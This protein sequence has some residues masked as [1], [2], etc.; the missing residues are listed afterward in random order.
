MK[1]GSGEGVGGYGP[2]D[3]GLLISALSRQ[4]VGFEGQ[5][6]WSSVPDRAATMLFG[7][8]QNH[9]FH[10][11]NKRTA[12]LS[13]V[14]YLYRNGY[15]ITV[16]E[17]A[18]EDL[19]V[20]IAT[21]GLRKFPRFRE[22]AKKDTDPEVRFLSH[23]LRQNT[24]KIDRQQYFITY[25]EL[26]KIL[27]RYDA[28]LENP[29]DNSIDLMRWETVKKKNGFF[30]KVSTGSEARRV[31]ALGFP[32]WTK[33]VGKGRISHIRKVLDLTPEFGVD[34]QAF[35]KDVDDMRVLI[36]MYEG[37]LERLAYR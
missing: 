8:I 18:L 28:W 4:F 12:Y 31:C 27:K 26:E 2:K 36:E 29:H 10:D 5:L 3:Y 9:P 7:L 15:L 32:G 16:T 1:K 19:T 20:L 21:N 17:K 24:R 22:L 11:A 35:F 34:S 23:Y 6:K 14:H 33:Q 13:T 37:A 25:R 30:S